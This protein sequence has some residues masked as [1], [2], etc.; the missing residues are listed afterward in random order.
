[1][2]IKRAIKIQLPTSGPSISFIMP[3]MKAAIRQGKYLLTVCLRDKVVLTQLEM[4]T[5]YNA[6]PAAYLS[7]NYYEYD[8]NQLIQV[9]I[10]TQK[11]VTTKIHCDLQ[12][13]GFLSFENTFIMSSGSDLYILYFETFELAYLCKFIPTHQLIHYS[14]NEIATIQHG[15][16]VIV[17]TETHS[18]QYSQNVKLKQ[19]A[20]TYRS[21]RLDE[22]I[23]IDKDIHNK[24][25]SFNSESSYL[26]SIPS[27]NDQFV[28]ITDLMG[29]LD[30]LTCPQFASFYD[31]LLRLSFSRQIIA[32]KK[33]IKANMSLDEQ[34]ACKVENVVNELNMLKAQLTNGVTIKELK[35]TDLSDTL[36][37]L[38][39]LDG[40][41]SS[42]Q[43][44]MVFGGLKLGQAQSNTQKLK[45]LQSQM[46]QQQTELD[47]MNKELSVAELQQKLEQL[48]LKAAA[49]QSAQQQAQQQAKQQVTQ[50]T[51]Q[52]VTE[53]HEQAHE[54]KQHITSQPIEKSE[55]ALNSNNTQSSQTKSALSAESVKQTDSKPFSSAQNQPQNISN[56]P[57]QK[58]SQPESAP[59]DLMRARQQLSSPTQPSASQLSSQP[60][61]KQTVT[62]NPT[63][64]N[65]Q[66][67]KTIEEVKTGSKLQQTTAKTEDKT[68]KPNRPLT[69][70]EK[71]ALFSKK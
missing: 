37:E 8:N 51:K 41:Q 13:T 38:G 60:P 32:M 57:D 70:A 49:K 64:T 48:E 36:I 43:P 16:L 42:K 44:D 54:S 22:F 24:L 50:V 12:I 35:L 9:D 27:F 28:L 21:Q 34:F 47:R 62:L 25:T 11:I 63:I 45:D 52:E 39:L 59:I 3:D 18:I 7:G 19:N 15:S 58:P 71:I 29:Q 65:N 31:N 53:A 55:N 1:M 66:V 61:N 5:L 33:E 23:Q 6:Q 56:K 68:E 40:Q 46:I 10:I 26:Q 69:M 14:P 67:Q 2:D 17:N 20:N 4:N 30:L